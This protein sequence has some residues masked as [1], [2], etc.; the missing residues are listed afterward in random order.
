[1]K[2]ELITF[3]VNSVAVLMVFHLIGRGHVAQGK[4]ERSAQ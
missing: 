4:E 2:H 1:M 3:T